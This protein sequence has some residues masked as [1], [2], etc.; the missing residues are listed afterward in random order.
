M[1]SFS[2]HFPQNE[3]SRGLADGKLIGL[4]LV[5]ETIHKLSFSGRKKKKKEGVA[6]Y[7]KALREMICSHTI[8]SDASTWLIELID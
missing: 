5:L 2:P 7:R 1:P 4:W 6:V 8:R 3:G